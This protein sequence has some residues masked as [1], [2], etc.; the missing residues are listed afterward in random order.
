MKSNR[1]TYIHEIIPETSSND[2]YLLLLKLID[3]AISSVVIAPCVIAYWRGTW[4]LMELILLPQY[5][6]TSALISYVIGCFGHI[7]FTI[8]QNSFKNSFDPEKKR[9]TYYLGS[10]GYTAIFGVIC[11]NMWRGAWNICDLLTSKTSLGVILL[12]TVVSLFILT[13]T[14]T[15]RNL[16]AAPFVVAIDGRQMYFD[17]STFFDTR[18]NRP[19]LYLLDTFFSVIFVGTLVVISWRG[20]WGS[21]D[22]VFYRKNTEMSALGSLVI[23]YGIVFITFVLQPCF[24]WICDSSTGKLKLFLADIYYMLSFMGAVN[25]WR[26]IWMILDIHLYPGIFLCLLPHNFGLN[27]PI[28]IVLLVL[29]PAE[30]SHFQFVQFGL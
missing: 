15:S 16:T 12:L 9:L 25:V 24:R 27:E 21:L 23:G 14:R 5:N 4:E 6:G 29:V 20:V 2:K 18:F 17:I 30:W 26:G 1:R 8:C 11:V 13:A 10:R 7:I 3:I 19:G 22:L 28:L